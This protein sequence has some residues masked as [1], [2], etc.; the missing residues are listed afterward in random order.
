MPRSLK[1][2]TSEIICHQVDTSITPEPTASGQHHDYFGN[3]V[4]AFSI[5][6]AHSS[7]EI[8]VSSDVTVSQS[9]V[10]EQLP[11][12]PWESVLE[13]ITES[14][15]SNWMFAKEFQYD[16]PRIMRGPIFAD[17]AVA[18][19]PQG[20]PII[21]AALELTKRIH[22]DFEYDTKVT[23]VGTSTEEAFEL[24]AGVCQDFAH[25]QIAC[26]RSLGIPARYVSGYLRTVP[27]EGQSRM[28]G[29]DESHAWV[30][31]YTGPELGWV[32]FDPT[33]ACPADTNHI[34]I[35]IGRDYSEV[36]P[37]RGVV[38][39]GG[40]ATLSVAVDVVESV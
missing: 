5:E 18:S 29:A 33:N 31:V 26:L 39:G 23:H 3:Q 20:R 15:D 17:Y 12:N 34:P 27:L 7:L 40:T 28:T 6:A 22:Q 2:R 24:K 35:C 9:K 38:I 10:I 36:S 32:D 4:I 21:E 8:M 37:T 19:F 30:S 11:S 14:T 13:S 1:T 25:V 16:S